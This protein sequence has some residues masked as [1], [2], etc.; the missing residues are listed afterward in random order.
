MPARHCSDCSHMTVPTLSLVVPVLDE[1]GTIGSF[2]ARVTPIVRQACDDQRYEIIFVD[3]GSRDAT[4]AEVLRCRERDPAVKLVIL[5]RNFGKDI[6]LSAGLEASRG[7]AVIP[8]DVD[9]QD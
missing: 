7:A 6:A 8:I 9:L 2:I 4:V 3:D 5:S 1:A